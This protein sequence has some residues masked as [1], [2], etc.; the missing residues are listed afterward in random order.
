MNKI[1]FI[2][3]LF[4]AKTSMAQ[5]NDQFIEHLHKN[6]MQ[7]EEKAYLNSLSLQ[8]NTALIYS[9]NS[10]LRYREDSLF[11]INYK[12][13]ASSYLSDSNR[14]TYATAYFL[15][16][17]QYRDKWLSEIKNQKTSERLNSI[18]QLYLRVEANE[19]I[20]SSSIPSPILSSYTSFKKASNKN[21]ILGGALSAIVPGLG[22][23][24]AGKKRRFVASFLT[25]GML[26]YQ[27]YES[28]DQLGPKHALSI[29]NMIIA[30]VFYAANVYGSYKDIQHYKSETKNQLYLDA[31][32]YY[33]S[34]FY[35]SKF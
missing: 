18:M 27:T 9:C 8:P 34:D 10:N 26:M 35:P 6:R 4:F 19:S 29:T 22:K 30:G 32:N 11:F 14:T 28:I 24:Y 17:K 23:L 31:S 13:C 1:A 5:V 12:Q 3:I 7:S 20:N 16:R 15:G 2:L 21:P 25:S 33:I